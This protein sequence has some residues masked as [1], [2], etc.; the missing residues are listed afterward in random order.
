MSMSADFDRSR[1]TSVRLRSGL[2][3]KRKQVQSDGSDMRAERQ[4]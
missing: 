4:C 3:R 2:D 1:Y